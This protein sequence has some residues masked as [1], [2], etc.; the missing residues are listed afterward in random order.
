MVRQEIIN[1]TMVKLGMLGDPNDPVDESLKT[2]LLKRFWNEKEPEKIYDLMS[3][4]VRRDNLSKE[5]V[6]DLLKFFKQKGLFKRLLHFNIQ[7]ME[8]M[9]RTILKEQRLQGFLL[10][11]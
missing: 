1:K 7:G 8:K 9:W 6:Q 11:N 5:A 2:K 3:K 10:E 4:L